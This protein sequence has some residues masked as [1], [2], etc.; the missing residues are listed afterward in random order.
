MAGVTSVL[1]T[2]R[3]VTVLRVTVRDLMSVVRRLCWPIGMIDVGRR[4][5]TGR[6]R[7]LIMGVM[8]LLSH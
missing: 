8:G 7:V 3:L 4:G 1:P 5:G 6:L 2:V